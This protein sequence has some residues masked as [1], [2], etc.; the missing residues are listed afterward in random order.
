MHRRGR[1]ATSGDAGS[2]GGVGTA[3]TVGKWALLGG[4]IGSVEPGG[5]T[6]AGALLGGLIDTAVT[7]A[8]GAGVD[9]LGQKCG[10]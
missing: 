4:V 1:P 2:G 5:G 3:Y 9:A 10:F 7:T 8:A 6:A